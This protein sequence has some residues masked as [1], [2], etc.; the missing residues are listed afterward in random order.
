MQPKMSSARR[1]SKFRKSL[2]TALSEKLFE[3]MITDFDEMVKK[4]THLCPRYPVPKVVAADA[5]ERARK[6]GLCFYCKEDGHRI[7][8]C[9]KRPPVAPGNVQG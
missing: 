3:D 7:A 5:R 9:P 2:H 6:D 4:A 8:D 1:A